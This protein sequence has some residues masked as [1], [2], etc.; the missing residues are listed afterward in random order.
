VVLQDSSNSGSELF[1]RPFSSP[2]DSRFPM[3]FGSYMPR[4]RY[5]DICLCFLVIP[6]EE[7]EMVSDLDDIHYNTLAIVVRKMPTYF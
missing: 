4:A 1:E 3:A 6:R 2:N 7:G 5:F